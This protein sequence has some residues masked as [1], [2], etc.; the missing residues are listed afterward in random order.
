[1]DDVLAT[2]GTAH[3]AGELADRLGA[4][5]AGM[6]FFIELQALQGRSRLPSRRLHSVLFL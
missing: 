4:E 3:A 2:G 6:A 5:V 1:V